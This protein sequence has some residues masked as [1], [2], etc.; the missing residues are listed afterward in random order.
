[1]IGC[2]DDNTSYYIDD[3]NCRYY[4]TQYIAYG[5]LVE[6]ELPIGQN[7]I[8]VNCDF[9]EA[10]LQLTCN[11]N[12]LYVNKMDPSLQVEKS[13]E[14]TWTYESVSDF[15][16]ESKTVGK[17]LY[18]SLGVESEGY[19]PNIIHGSRES[20]TNIY[21]E[22]K[23]LVQ[24]IIDG[25]WTDRDYIEWDSDGRPTKAAPTTICTDDEGDYYE[26]DDSL[27]IATH[28]WN[29]RTS[30]MPPGGGVPCIP[31]FEKT[32]FDED[33][34]EISRGYMAPFYN[35]FYNILTTGTVCN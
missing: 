13:Q 35:V 9:D 18:L 33:G 2:G 23:V 31:W 19:V 17:I 12:W 28:F 8:T 4:A 26:Y 11:A 10:T 29:S 32:H 24:T 25:G 1:M 20:H 30:T 3:S 22:Q 7:E 21:D 16:E 6:D 14:K 34:N 5:E 27:R 15:I